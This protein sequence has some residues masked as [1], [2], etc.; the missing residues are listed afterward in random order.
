MKLQAF[1]NDFFKL[2]I[3]DITMLTSSCKLSM[4]HFQILCHL[5]YASP[6]LV[7]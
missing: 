2:Q 4:H 5:L 6:H 7:E 1:L 3:F